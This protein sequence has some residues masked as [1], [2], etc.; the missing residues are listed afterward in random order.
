MFFVTSQAFICAALSFMSEPQFGEMSASTMNPGGGQEVGLPAAI[1][2]S[3]VVFIVL[4]VSIASGPREKLETE[5][6]CAGAGNTS[7]A[8]LTGLTAF[9][10]MATGGN[11]H[12]GMGGGGGV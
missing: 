3:A 6:E 11:G 5:G 12:V 8:S 4:V 9:V 7:A 2:M 1:F 10:A